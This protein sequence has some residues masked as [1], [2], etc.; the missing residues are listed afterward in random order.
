MAIRIELQPK[1]LPDA[2]IELLLPFTT[3]EEKNALCKWLHAVIVSTGFSSNIR[4]LVL[5]K[6]LTISRYNFHDCHV[7]L[8]GLSP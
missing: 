1:E 8:T 3:S 6:D 2:K 4:K 5:M 7:M